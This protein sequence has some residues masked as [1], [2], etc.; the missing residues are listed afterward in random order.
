MKNNI[1]IYKFRYLI[2]MI[3]IIDFTI[4]I[5]RYINI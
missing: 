5:Y 2:R 3:D 1:E 4:L